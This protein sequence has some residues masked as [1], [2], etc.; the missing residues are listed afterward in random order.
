MSRARCALLALALAAVASAHARY[1]ERTVRLVIASSIGSGV[2]V[3]SRVLAEELAQTLG[4]SFVADNRAGAGT[5]IG[6]EIGARAAPDGY[7]VL[8]ATSA[9]AA[10]VS[11]YRQLAYDPVR[12]FSPVSEVATGLYVICVAPGLPVKSLRELIDLARAKPD[13][14]TYASGGT[15]TG[16][17]LAAEYFK[18]VSGARLLHVPYKGGGPAM[19]AVMAGEAAVMFAPFANC[20]PYARQGRVR[21]LAMTGPRRSPAAPD[22]PT[23]AEAGLA[24]YDFDAWYGM[25]VP[26]RTPRAIVETLHDAVVAALRKPALEA[27]LLDLG[28]VPVGSTPQAFADHIRSEIVK[29]GRVIR[30][31]GLT[32]N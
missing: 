22:V 19:T 24:Q 5:N 6:I 27:R 28:Y 18:S 1:P 9:L 4:Q 17:F 10:N 3:V 23:P 30:D 11:L 2:D 32:A 12:D 13:A 14:V 20:H 16:S 29:L 26:A 8:M 25:L 7:T 21:M 31:T 15:G